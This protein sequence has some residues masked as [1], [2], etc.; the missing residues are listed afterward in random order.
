MNT[1]SR[2]NKPA[3][4]Q[5]FTLIELM[6]VV[7]IIGILAAIVVPRMIGTADEA[8]VTAAKA[9][10][11]SFKQALISYKLKFGKFPTTSEGL[12]VLISNPKGSLLDATQIPSDP[13]GNPYVYTCP[14]SKGQD[15]EIVSYGEDGA[16]GGEG[17][18]A[19]IVSYD[20]QGS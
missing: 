1:N 5:G 17:L 19:D 9:Q 18:D 11:T 6:V 14:G 8:K 12:D 13:W 4:N 15:F 7:V 16:P 3:G 20:L 10:I 2:T